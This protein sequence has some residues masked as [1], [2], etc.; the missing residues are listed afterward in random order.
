[1]KRKKLGLTDYKSRL[2]LILSKKPR[3]VVRRSLNKLTAQLI[4]YD[5]KGDKI[6]FS[7]DTKKLKEFG[8]KFHTGNLPS[9]YLLGYLVGFEAKKIK[10]AEVV[11]DIGLN[12]SINGSSIYA[13][14]K[15]ALDSG[16]KIPHDNQIL[17]SE[18][19]IKGKHIINY[20]SK[21]SQND[22][23]KQFSKY[24]K[25]NVNVGNIEKDFEDIKSKISN[26]YKNA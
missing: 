18:D 21:L 19:R 9:A 22:K 14:L 5:K 8:W 15:G 1:L 3:L 2:N 11:L 13:L 16:L 4:I 24:L 12:E 26:K 20:Y 6:L 17:P 25:N 7:F 23:N 10:L